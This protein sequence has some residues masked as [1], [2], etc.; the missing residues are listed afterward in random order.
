M[1]FNLYDYTFFISLFHPF[2]RQK[3]HE[4]RKI[5]REKEHQKYL[6]EFHKSA[7]LALKKFIDAI[8]AYPKE[9]KV[10]IEFGTLL[11]AYRDQKLI[12]HDSDMDFGINEEDMSQDLIE[13]LKKYDFH[14]YKKYIIESNNKDINDFTAEYTFQYGKYVAIDLFVFKTLNNQKVCFSFDA[15][16]GLKY[17]ETLKKYNNRLRTIQIN[18]SNFNL[19]KISFMNN[20]VYIPD[21][22]LDHLAEIYGEDFMIPKVYSYGDRIKDFE[23]LLDNQTLGRKVEFRRK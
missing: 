6:I 18:L 5:F 9:V 8:N 21:N 17:G 15:E 4:L 23:I 14:L 19:K 2:N 1:K 11:G 3:R 7:P 13:H 10:W 12:P 20:D 22:T 16:E